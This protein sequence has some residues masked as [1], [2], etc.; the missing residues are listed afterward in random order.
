MLF[1]GLAIFKE[2]KI[3]S[4]NYLYKIGRSRTRTWLF[5]D[6]AVEEY[7]AL[8]IKKLL[9]SSLAKLPVKKVSRANLYLTFGLRENILTRD[10][11]NMVKATED[12]V[13]KVTRFDDSLHFVCHSEKILSPIGQEF[14]A[15]VLELIDYEV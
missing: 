9:D 15:I 13:V 11:T 12:A 1:D 8:L 3:P 4:E 5:K 2:L 6:P 14:V 7:Q 10:T